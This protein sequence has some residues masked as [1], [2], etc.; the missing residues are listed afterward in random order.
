MRPLSLLLLAAASALAACGDSSGPSSPGP[1]TVRVV[2]DG[3]ATPV[4]EARVEVQRD[5]GGGARSAVTGADGTARFDSLAPGSY[6][7]AAVVPEGFEAPPPSTGVRVA[8]SGAQVELRAVAVAAAT[9]SLP[10]GDSDTLTLA[11]GLAA[12]V[13]SPAAGGTPLT[14]SLTAGAPGGFARFPVVGAPATLEVTA[15]ALARGGA[16]VRGDETLATLRVTQRVPTCE[17]G[18]ASVAFEV[19]GPR[20]AGDPGLFLYAEATCTTYVDAHTGRTGSALVAETEVTRPG[21]FRLAAFTTRSICAPPSLYAQP[22]S[23]ERTGATPVIFI[24]GLQ[25]DRPFCWMYDDFRP[26]VDVFGDLAASLNADANVRD[27]YQFYY[28]RYPTHQRIAN[29][30]A[31][32]RAE[33]ERRGWTEREVVLVGH[34]MGGLVA[35]GYAAQHGTDRVKALVTL[36]T[37]HAGS[38]LADVGSHPLLARACVGRWG[39]AAPLLPRTDGVEDLAPGSAWIRAL[40]AAP[41]RTQRT[42]AFAGQVTAATGVLETSQC[43]LDALSGGATPSDGVVPVASAAPAWTTLQT[44]LPLDHFALS[45]AGPGPHVRQILQELRRCLAGPVP[46][47]PAANAFPLAGTVARQADG[48]VDVVLNPI[49]VGGRPVRGLTA[50]N[51]AIVEEDCLK[52][53]D[54]TTAEGNVGV[55]LVFVQD[56]SG[57]MSDAIAGVRRSVLAFSA[58]LATRG[59]NLRIGSVGFSGPGT[60]TTHANQGVCERVGPFRPLTRPDTFHAHVTA[61]W[62]ADGGCDGPENALEAIEYAHRNLAWRPGAARIYVLITDIGMHT[63]GTSCNGLGACTDQ[64][65]TSIQALI[66][67]TSTVHVVAPEDEFSRTYA[68]S[69][70]PWRLADA[71]G[72]RRLVLPP[73]GDVDL[74]ALE[75]ADEIAQV[76][77]LTFRSSSPERAIHTLRVRV[78]VDGAVAELAPGLVGYAVHPSLR[79]STP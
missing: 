20:A 3:A 38:V 62:T 1:L 17:G 51:F 58:G 55:D 57:S 26:E 39:I 28:F 53:F 15:P 68:G 52:P 8:S 13:A 40:T 16:A 70:D 54:V 24:H 11:S 48:R 37:P 45:G 67:A 77:R 36:G 79:R 6:R 63:A 30:A 73:G 43:L 29:A 7:V 18:T 2:S 76:V 31:A 19:E 12:V 34:S 14:V 61:Q 64:T 35:R 9:A 69:A 60:I 72:G 21:T 33:I 46:A 75:I 56:L 23:P 74:N 78:T 49:V 42:Y 27:G 71:T 22:G 47:R 59:L 41:S 5:G 50:A 44:R 25:I 10:A 32:L 66:G 4:A 65:L